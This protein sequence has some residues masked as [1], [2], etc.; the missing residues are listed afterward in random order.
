MQQKELRKT[1]KQHVMPFLP[2]LTHG[3][4]ILAINVAFD[5][6][7]CLLLLPY[8]VLTATNP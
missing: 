1:I 5:R 4:K 6:T 8:G 3:N 2:P 7:N